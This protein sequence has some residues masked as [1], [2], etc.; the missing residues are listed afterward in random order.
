[1][2]RANVSPKERAR[3]RRRAGYTLIEIMTALAVLMV[4][5]T[6]IFA[7]QT[8]STVAN[9]EA[10]RMGTAGQ[11]GQLV[12]ERIRRDALLWRSGGSLMNL[13]ELA[14]TTYL[15]DAPAAGSPVTAWMNVPAGLNGFDYYGNGTTVAGDMVYCAQYRLAWVYFGQALR[16]DVRV[17]YPRRGDGTAGDTSDAT[18]GAGCPALTGS[19]ASLIEDLHLIHYST[20]IRWTPEAP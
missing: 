17:Y 20:I 12:V 10:R 4:G 3:R 11:V 1:M 5:A 9:M 7:I 18:V 16:A 6:G 13:T 14:A 19:S 8:G 2:K 15:A